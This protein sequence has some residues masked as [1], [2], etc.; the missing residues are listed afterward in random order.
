MAASLGIQMLVSK[1]TQKLIGILHPPTAG[2]VTL[3]INDDIIQLA[4]AIWQTPSSI[5]PMAR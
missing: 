4:K 2:K 5:P 3:L 1:N